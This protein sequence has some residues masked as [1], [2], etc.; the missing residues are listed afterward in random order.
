MTAK[1]H[2]KHPDG[3]NVLPQFGTARNCSCFYPWCVPFVLEGPF[4]I[5]ESPVIFHSVG[6]EDQICWVGPCP[7]KSPGQ[8]TSP[9]STRMDFPWCFSD[10]FRFRW[11]NSNVGRMGPGYNMYDVIPI[12]FKIKIFWGV[13]P[14][15]LETFDT[16]SP[17]RH[18]CN[19]GDSK[20]IAVKVLIPPVHYDQRQSSGSVLV[21]RRVCWI[22]GNWW[23]FTQG[24][25]QQTKIFGQW[26]QWSTYFFSLGLE[27]IKLKWQ[28]RLEEHQLNSNHS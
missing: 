15:L 21:R 19:Q 25:K 2:D 24:G 27:G 28:Q 26:K 9:F 8:R 17:F 6:L 1:K 4:I 5:F 13:T 3:L 10:W 11:K 22:C 18:N 14:L 20:S 16:I 23:C 7:F 12:R